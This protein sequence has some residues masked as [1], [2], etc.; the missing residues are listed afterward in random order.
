[1][2]T[3]LAYKTYKKDGQLEKID[4]LSAMQDNPREAALVGYLAGIFDGEGT[5]G[6]KKYLPKGKNRTMCY[7]LYL[8][9]GMQ[10][11]EV[12]YLFHDILGGNIR[13]ERVLNRRSMWRWNATGKLHVAA[14]LNMLLPY[15]RV[16]KLQALLALDCCNTWSLQQTIG[17]SS[18]KTSDTELLKREEAYL[19]MRKL[20]HQE[21]PQRLNELAPETVK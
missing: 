21:H 10:D 14:I 9:V 16:K 4:A 15:L 7:Y 18:I 6:I 17:H 8:Y 19:L 11:K 13:E 1:M 5:V 2:A 12:M 3:I 20:K